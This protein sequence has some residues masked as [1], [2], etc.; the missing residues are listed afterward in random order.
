MMFGI[1]EEEINA[2]AE[3]IRKGWVTRFQSG[4]EGYLAKSERE[5]AKMAGV[6][7][8]LMMNSGTSALISAMVAL[9]IGPGD[10]VLVSAYTWI[11]TPLAP[12]ILGAI[13][14]LVEVDESLTM[15]P[16]DLARKIT[17]RTKA[18]M[19]IHMANRPCDMDRIMEIA[20]KHNIPVV[21]D[22]CQAVGGLYKGKR[23]GSIGTIGT[24]SFNN[25]KNITCG[26]GGA[27]LTDDDVL[28]DRAK[29]YHDAGTFVQAYD[30]KVKVPLF[31]GQDYRASDIQ[32][33][34]LFEQLKRLDPGMAQWRTRVRLA[35][36]L[37]EKGGKFKV[38][39]HYDPETAVNLALIFP[40]AAACDAFCKN[41]GLGGSIFNTAGRHV[42]LNWVPLVEKRAYRDEANPFLTEAGQ[43]ACYDE[44][45][46][47]KTIDILKRT[48]YLTPAWNKSFEEVEA[49]INGL[50]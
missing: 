43:D 13:P 28:Y 23:L 40:T 44:T 20:N 34:I 17:P 36:E 35:T 10:E 30:A 11:S 50:K 19:V 16:D 15:D 22:A 9:G 12:V 8:A 32:G 38:S 1:G 5:L 39:K 6:K 45:A 46:A 4:T 2:V 37:I 33:A 48:A 26:E 41:N 3:T 29:N 42:Y 31:A 14:R 27:L 24:F 25:Y 21:E 47:P 18:I 7:H 49:M